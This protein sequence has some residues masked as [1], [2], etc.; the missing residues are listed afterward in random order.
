MGS[1]DK[2][3]EWMGCGWGS[4]LGEVGNGQAGASRNSMLV[5]IHL[6]I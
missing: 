5:Q 3:T 6:Y 1:T 2:R 4:R